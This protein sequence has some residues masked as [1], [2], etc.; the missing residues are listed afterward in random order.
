MWTGAAHTITSIFCTVT[1]EHLRN[2]AH[3]C[4]LL[5]CQRTCNLFAFS[6][7]LIHLLAWPCGSI[8]SGQRL[9][10]VIMM[11]LSMEK[12]SLGR[13]A[14]SQSR[15]VTGSPSTADRE[16]LGLYGRPYGQKKQ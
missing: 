11:A 8:I 2:I 7:A 4:V 3:G 13:P 14:R 10:L 5:V 1:R 6:L 9:L 16:Y 12:A 15:M